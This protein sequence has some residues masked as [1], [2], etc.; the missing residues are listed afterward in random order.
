MVLDML[1]YFSI[2][3]E[4]QGK[5]FRDVTVHIWYLSPSWHYIQECNL[6]I[7]TTMSLMRVGSYESK[8][9]DRLD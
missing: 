1:L 5:V 8:F 7:L 2:K 4:F 6:K 3:F 9:S